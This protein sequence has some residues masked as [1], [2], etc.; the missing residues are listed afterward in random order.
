MQTIILNL[1]QGWCDIHEKFGVLP[2]SELFEYGIQ[3]AENGFVVTEIIAKLWYDSII[4]F[5]ND[6]YQ[7]EI[8]T[9]NKYPTICL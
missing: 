7:D 2:W 3:Y 6:T 9:N 4:T 1:F 5:S 8:T